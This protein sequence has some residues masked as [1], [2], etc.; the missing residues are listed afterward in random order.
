MTIIV[1]AKDCML[2][3]VKAQEKMGPGRVADTSRAL[4]VY[5]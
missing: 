4:L 1:Y 3:K 2:I 5:V